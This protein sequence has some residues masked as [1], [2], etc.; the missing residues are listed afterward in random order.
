MGQNH[1]QL[2][3]PPGPCGQPPVQ[4]E[5]TQ[6]AQH[7]QHVIVRKTA[8]DLQLDVMGSPRLAAE[9]G[10]DGLDGGQEEPGEVSQGA[11]LDLAARAVG[12]AEEVALVL[13]GPPGGW[14]PWLRAA[15]PQLALAWSQAGCCQLPTQAC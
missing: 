7:R 11:V 3:L 6:A 10:A 8:L 14:A 5:L 12:L 4:A 9:A 1:H 15:H 13:R 2:S